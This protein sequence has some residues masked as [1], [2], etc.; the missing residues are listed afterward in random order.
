MINPAPAVPFFVE[1]EG[2]TKLGERLQLLRIEEENE[3]YRILYTLTAMVADCAETLTDN[4]RLIEKLDYSFSK[5][6]LSLQMN[7]CEPCINLDR[8][9]LLEKAR[10]PL[11]DPQEGMGIAIAIL[12]KLRESGANF[13]VTTERN[14]TI[15]SENTRPKLLNPV[16]IIDT[17]R[18]CSER[19]S[20]GVIFLRR[21]AGAPAECLW[22]QHFQEE[23]EG[24]ISPN[25][26]L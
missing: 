8:R 4:M 1:P 14:A 21:N 25:L 3:V 19:H 9:I 5:G 26:K 23:A 10:H 11:M 18:S 6:K 17:I 12:E 7:A 16:R 24:R 15:W 22:I 13:L 2:V 20:G